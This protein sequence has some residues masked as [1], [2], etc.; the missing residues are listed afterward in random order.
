MSAAEEKAESAPAAS[1][2]GE[3]E[4]GGG[5]G[6]GKLVLILTGVNILA[7][8]A[9]VGILFMS[10]QKEKA[11]PSVDDISL[12]S[13]A[14]GKEAKKEGEGGEKGKPEEKKK[15]AEFGKMIQLE[16]FVVNLTTP[17]SVNP[18]FVRVNVVLEVPNDESEQEVTAKMPQ[19]RN[20]I[21]DLFNS[22][23]PSDMANAEGKDYLKE[24]IRN[25]IN[26]FMVTGKVKGVF[27]TNFALGS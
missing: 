24:E 22:K 10:F 13:A 15:S 19:V 14:D 2:S 6:P 8:L 3:S 25:A 20:T 9:M 7:T 17:G 18:K 11:K 5:G 23:R 12:K 4:G 21:I 26:G 1:A 27:F 16:Q